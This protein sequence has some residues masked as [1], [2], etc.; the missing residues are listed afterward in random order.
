[1]KYKYSVRPNEMKTKECKETE[2]ES[3]LFSVIKP[4]ITAAMCP[5]AISRKIPITSNNNNKPWQTVDCLLFCW[6]VNVH[7]ARKETKNNTMIP[8]VNFHTKK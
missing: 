5:N 8:T 3:A 1:M 2:M 6:C 4:N 7:C